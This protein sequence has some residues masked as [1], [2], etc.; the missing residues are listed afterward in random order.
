MAVSYVDLGRRLK[1][2]RIAA[3]LK[4]EDVADRLGL[5]RAA[6]YRLERGEIVKVEVLEKVAALLNVSLALLMGV[7]VEYYP[8]A[9]DFFGRM[10]ELEENTDQLLAHF[11]PVSFLLTSADY[12]EYLRA[13]LLEAVPADIRAT[14]EAEIA[15][16]IDEVLEILGQRKA[17]FTR[18]RANIISL[19][20]TREIERFLHVGLVGRLSLPTTIHSQRIAAAKREMLHMAELIDSEPMGVQIGVVDDTLPPFAFQ[21]F[22]QPSRDYVAISAFRLGELPNIRTGVATVTASHE[23]VALYTKMMTDLWERSRKGRE[24]AALIRQL[25]QRV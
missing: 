4:A 22:R 5:S 12:P 24:G 11:E 16:D 10:C 1:A 6:V 9:S 15:R 18:K 21:I 25:V 14:H 2:W 3:S 7:E 17:Q 19:V 8:R 20:G 23:A 13:M